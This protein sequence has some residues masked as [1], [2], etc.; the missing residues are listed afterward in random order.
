[1]RN[2]RR[3]LLSCLFL[4]ALMSQLVLAQDAYRLFR[5]DVQYLYA[6]PAEETS[7]TSSVLGMRLGS[8]NCETTYTSA[9]VSPFAA[10]PEECIQRVSAF[11]GSQVCHN[12]QTTELT[13]TIAGIPQ[14]LTIMQRANPGQNWLAMTQPETIYGRVEDVTVESFL[15]LTDSVKYIAL[16]RENTAGQFIPLYEEVPIRISRNYG[17]ISGVFLHWLGLET[18]SIELLGMSDPP[19]GLQ[20]PTRE[21]LFQLTVGDVLHLKK[22]DTEF[23]PESFQQVHTEDQMIVTDVAWNAGNTIL[24]YTFESDRKRYFEGPGASTDTLYSEEV[25]VQEIDWEELRYL[26]QQPGAIVIDPDLPSSIR[27]L[28]LLPDAFCEQT[29][30]RLQYPVLQ[31]PDSCFTPWLDVF[32]G[33]VYYDQLAGP[34]FNFVG[35]SGFQVCDLRYVNLSNGFSCG[36]PF[37]VMVNVRI[38]ELLEFKLFPNPASDYVQLSWNPF[39]TPTLTVD[40]YDNTGRCLGRN[41]VVS[42]G[43]RLQLTGFSKGVYALKCTTIDGSEYLEKLVVK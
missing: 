32:E 17:L 5:P 4:L 34:Y 38:P 29:G 36:D 14:V 7:Y 27:V 19:V 11:I 6:N 12:E 2:I 21:H 25:F 31:S 1:M 10:F 22:V 41:L 30:K 13:I 35:L 3:H 40:L 39:A 20:N 16:Y 18:G 24:T 37:D 15:G 33:P 8:Q 26:E 23:T 43:E 9:Q 28:A 42:N